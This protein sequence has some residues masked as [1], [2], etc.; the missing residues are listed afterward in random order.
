M[1]THGIESVCLLAAACDA[2]VRAH[3][4]PLGT[5]LVCL[6]RRWGLP[7]HSEGAPSSSSSS[8]HKV[9]STIG[10]G[11]VAN[12]RFRDKIPR[13]QTVEIILL[14]VCSSLG[15]IG[16]L[17]FVQ[18][19]HS[20]MNVSLFLFMVMLSTPFCALAFMLITNVGVTFFRR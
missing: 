11:S 2:L 17:T 10:I 19:I 9:S 8:I 6:R 5:P 16:Y 18:S 20:S 3:R 7:R 13:Y 4:S 12:H 1:K 14:V 15:G